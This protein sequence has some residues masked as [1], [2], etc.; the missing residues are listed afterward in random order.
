MVL[1]SK[2]LYP[3]LALFLAL[4]FLIL[5]LSLLFPNLTLF[6]LDLESNLPT[7]YQG[8]KLLMIGSSSVMIL[9]FLYILGKDMAKN[10]FWIFWSALFFFLGLD[11]IGEIHENVSTYMKEILGKEIVEYEEAIV[12]MGYSSTPWLLYYFFFFIIASV[13]VAMY[14]GQKDVKNKRYLIVGWVLFIS[15]LLVELINTQQEIMFNHGYLLLMSI[16]EM[17]EMV[18]ASFLLF[19]S[20]LKLFE[21]VSVVKKRLKGES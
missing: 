12:E 17:L 15:V 14:L 9:V 8:F 11:E 18:G 4:D 3:L 19:F 13:L 1:K 7:I 5:S 10:W 6:N 20:L 2:K 21:L 16:E